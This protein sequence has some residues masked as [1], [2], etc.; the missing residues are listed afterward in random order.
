MWWSLEVEPCSVFKLMTPMVARELGRRL[1][2]VLANL[3]HL[4][5]AQETP[6][7]PQ[8]QTRGSTRKKV[9]PASSSDSN[10][11]CPPCRSTSSR[12]MYSPS[13]VPLILH[14]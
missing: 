14:A 3:K 11:R 13:P 9:E 2:T 10:Q 8:L 7:P 12:Q 5:E 6:L 4:L 1:D